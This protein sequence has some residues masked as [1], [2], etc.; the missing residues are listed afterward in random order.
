[1][2]SITQS[3]TNVLAL[4][5]NDPET[6]K[7]YLFGGEQ[8]C[9]NKKIQMLTGRIGLLAL[10]LPASPLSARDDLRSIYGF[11]AGWLA[12]LGVKDVQN[13]IS[14]ERDR[15]D[16]LFVE[17]KIPFNCASRVASIERKLRVLVEEVGEV[18]EAIDRCELS[19]PGHL[20]ACD[21]LIEELIQVGAVCVAWLESMEGRS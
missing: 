13:R 4:L 8:V 1:M 19:K 9:A 15:Q 5:D 20:P 11:I 2:S 14:A 16:E 12:S 10:V 21:H 18:A 3:R 17:G 6:I 7:F